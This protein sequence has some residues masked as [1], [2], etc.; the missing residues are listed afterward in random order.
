M[1][2]PE[3]EFD[4]ELAIHFSQAGETILEESLKNPMAAYSVIRFDMGKFT[5]IIELAKGGPFTI[6][7]ID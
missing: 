1:L 6:R 4:D 3:Y 2:R 5:E 7:I